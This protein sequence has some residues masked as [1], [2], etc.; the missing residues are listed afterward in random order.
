MISKELLSEV[1]KRNIEYTGNCG[2]Q[3]EFKYLMGGYTTINFY[4]L[5][6]LCK[7]WAWNQGLILESGHT[8]TPYCTIVDVSE[9]STMNL[10]EERFISD[11]EP[12]AIFAA[13]QW[14]LDQQTK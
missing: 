9:N 12:E 7:E 1:L 5:A 13:C 3:V 8:N 4:E 2:G 14:I 6:H 10:G 11:S